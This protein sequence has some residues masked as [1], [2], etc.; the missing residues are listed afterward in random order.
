ML[1][2]ILT[3]RQHN[4]IICVNSTID[5]NLHLYTVIYVLYIFFLVYSPLINSAIFR[6]VGRPQG[7]ESNPRWEV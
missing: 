4:I 2:P 7:R 6:T 1:L 5:D 3:L